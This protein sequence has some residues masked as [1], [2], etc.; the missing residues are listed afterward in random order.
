VLR[1]L[2]ALREEASRLAARLA[3]MRLRATLGQ[4]AAPDETLRAILRE[5]RLA[6]S[7]DGLA[8]A[9][10][11]LQEALGEDP[12]RPAR[13][14]RLT[15]L[16]RFLSEARAIDLEPG[17]AQELLELPRRNLVKPPGDAGLHGA[18]PPVAI[19]RQLPFERDR[20]K[21]GELESALAEAL[22]G[23]DGARGAV[24]EAREA[25]MAE[26][27]LAPE[28]TSLADEALAATD[29]LVQ[30]LGAWLLERNTGA[31]GGFARHDLL[32]LLH[33]PRCAPA[34]PRG[35]L[36]RTVRRWAEMLRLD[37]S[38]D[39][40]IRVDEDDRPLKPSG[41]FALPVDPPY[42]AVIGVLPEEGPRALGRLLFAV[43]E[44]QRWVG[45]S[46]EAPPEDLWLGDAALPIA[47]GALF[48]GLLREP[49]FVRRC[50][51]ADLA[52]DDERSLAV[53]GV[54]DLRICAARA[55]ASAQARDLGPGGRTAQAHRELY[56]RATLTELPTGLALDGLDAFPSALDELRGRALAAGMRA[57]LR[58]RHDEDWWRNPRALSALQSVWALGGRGTADELWS[59]ISIPP[60][61]APMR[62]EFIDACR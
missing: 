20:E 27:G 12:R 53:A 25:A 34:F 54:F 49:Q 11:A 16:R 36:L 56:A 28:A 4:P 30:D 15:A 23:Y 43:G 50:A 59:Q 31:K 1:E 37:L 35:E 52:R 41:S 8:Q 13:V 60:S 24:F 5:H 51:K 33:A 46:S 57:W 3:R 61:M 6:S 38:A 10:E 32:H 58:E 21:R 45:P 26:A 9:R 48:E 47:C 44:A 17:A 2:P 40:C 14:A 39:G 18:L 19:E 42:E 55:L 29:D 7:S 62:M 22:G